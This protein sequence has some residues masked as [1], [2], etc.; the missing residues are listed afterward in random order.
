MLK[1]NKKYPL[2]VLLLLAILWFL[3]KQW[4][5]I[6]NV[7]LS[8]PRGLY[9]KQYGEL[10]RGGIVS[11]CLT[12]PYQSFGL[13]RLY[14]AKG[15]ACNGADALIKEVIAI[16]GDSVVLQ[17]NFIKV[18]NTVYLYKTHYRDSIGRKLFVCPRGVYKN[19]TGYWVIGVNDSRSWDSRY[20][21][22]IQKKQIIA[23]LRPIF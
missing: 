9:I 7:T 21:G 5:L 14:I 19:I 8:M 6:I 16:P 22:E 4:G 15:V 17:D 20:W 10:S 3:V 23:K 1:L 2:I 18:N 12:K 13:Q 11:F